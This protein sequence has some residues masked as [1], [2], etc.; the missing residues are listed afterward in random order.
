[1]LMEKDIVW[2]ET[3]PTVYE[4]G[5]QVRMRLFLICFASMGGLY[6]SVYNHSFSLLVFA[7]NILSIFFLNTTEMYCEMFFLFPYTMIYKFN[8]GSTSLFT[9]LTLVFVL[10]LLSGPSQ[11]KADP[12][13]W[14]F[15]DQVRSGLFN[16]IFF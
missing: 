9:Y 14:E 7:L 3:G 13:Q 5:E 16:D 1:M 4:K 2:F 8:V 10:V 15:R 6:L 12:L 11:T